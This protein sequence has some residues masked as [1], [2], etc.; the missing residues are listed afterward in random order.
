MTLVTESQDMIEREIDAYRQEV[1]TLERQAASLL[2]TDDASEEAALLF[3]AECKRAYAKLEERRDSKV[4]PLNAE[5]KAINEG[6]RPYTTVLDRLWRT[7][8]QIRGRYVTQKQ[9]AIEAANRR[10]IADAAEAKRREE[11]RAEAAR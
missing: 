6:F 4:R 9:Q 3:I 8:D 2:V 7:T 5:V 11:A 1:E 10:A